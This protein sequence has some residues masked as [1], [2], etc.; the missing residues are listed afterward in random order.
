MS[1]FFELM[2]AGNGA[3]LSDRSLSKIAILSRKHNFTIIVDEIMTGGRTGTLLLLET[4]AIDFIQCVSHVTLGKWCRCGIVLVSP[5]QNIIEQRQQDTATAP[6]SNSTTIDLAQIIPY[7]N[8]LME[9]LL[10]AQIRRE[11]VFDKT[12][13]KANDAWGV[14]AI[15][16]SSTKNNTKEGLNHRL[17]PMLELTNIEKGNMTKPYTDKEDFKSIINTKIIIAIKN[18]ND[19]SIYDKTTSKKVSVYLSLIRFLIKS[20]NESSDE[21]EVVLS[22][23]DINL[24]LNRKIKKFPLSNMLSEMD[25]AGLIKYQKSGAKRLRNWVVSKSFLFF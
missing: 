10:M 6:R 21:K 22:T 2:L 12:K 7:W 20:S 11:M 13:I 24:G 5:N 8:K 23:E 14:G 4:K 9:I 25:T 15:I 18:W 17:L 1:L 3:I 16:F 19:V